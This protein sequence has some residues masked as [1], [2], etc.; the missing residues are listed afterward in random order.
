MI[1]WHMEAVAEV[2]E[3][4]EVVIATVKEITPYGVYA[5]LDE[6]GGMMGFLHISEI[7]T[8]WVR[9]IEKFVKEGQKVVLK[10]IK[11]SKTRK[12]VNLSLR[13]VTAE[14][15]REKLIEVKRLEKA[16]GI[17]EAVRNKLGIGAEE[18]KRYAEILVDEFGGLYEALEKLVKDGPK[19]VEKPGLPEGFVLALEQAA[20]EKLSK[21]EVSITGILEL[22][23]NLSDGVVVIREALKAGEAVSVGGAKVKI[24][25]VGSPRYRVV[26]TADNFKVAERALQAVLEK[27]RKSIEK[28]GTF[29]FN[30]DER[31]K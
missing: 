21:P 12:E 25:Y 18:G 11:V 14:E 8:G 16:R 20:K 29:R 23:S 30:R 2:P 5:S 6:Y 4:G 17:F 13:Q 3:E 26:I 1:P 19:A 22:T 9:N 15:R 7:S 31:K 27:V 28:K 10:V 24:Y